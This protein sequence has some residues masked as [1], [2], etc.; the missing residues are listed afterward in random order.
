[1]R[2]RDRVI[3]IVLGVVLGLGIVALFVFKFSNQAIDNPV[4]AGGGG[5]GGGGSSQ[6]SKP[7][8]PPVRTV[9]ISGC[10]PNYTAGAPTLDYHQGDHVRSHFVSD[11]T[12][13]LE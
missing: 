8:E 10:A 9:H 2:A 1:M 13:V 12:C 3:G 4:G 5:G 11:S 7:A 6:T